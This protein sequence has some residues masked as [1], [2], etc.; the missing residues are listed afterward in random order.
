[1]VTALASLW[2]GVCFA[3]G[4]FGGP[5]V[6]GRSGGAG[7][8]RPSPQVRLRYFA[9]VR[10]VYDSGLT[11]INQDPAAPGSFGLGG[12]EAIFGVVGTKSWRKTQLALT[13]Q[14]GYR[15][16]NQN[17]GFNGSDHALTVGVSHAVGR[18]ATLT[19]S[20]VVATMTRA[21]G[22]GFGLNFLQSNQLDPA[23][24]N[25]P[26]SD[27]LDVRM[28][29]A[30]TSNTLQYRFGPRLSVAATGGLN[31]IQRAGGLFASTGFQARGDISYRISRN[32]TITVDYGAQS[33]DFR[34]SYGNTFLQNVAVQYAAA[35]GRRWQLNLRGG[36][37][38]IK[39]QGLQRVQLRPEIAEILGVRVGLEAFYRVNY[40]P[41][42]QV[43]LNGRFR[44][45]TVSLVANRG[46]IPGNG[47]ILMSS[48]Q[49]VSAS[50]NY[51]GI[52]HWTFSGLG[53]WTRMTNLVRFAAR[54]EGYTAGG[55][56]GYQ[57][58]P[59]LQLNASAIYRDM[60]TTAVSRFQRAGT[61][62]A[63]GLTYSPGDIPLS[64]W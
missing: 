41:N 23:F 42:F 36:G 17:V 54:N 2:A 18:R 26:F 21:F 22:F 49:N 33:F 52:R 4:S 31:T 24:S 59:A 51:V 39:N 47:I 50:Y 32:Q 14:G 3:Q 12:V 25:F 28:N 10:G 62:I 37:F 46:V 44:S 35:I 57:I 56:V 9:T 60:Q 48:T 53:G 6:L 58:R 19:T 8:G 29:F 61:R 16:Y 11:A 30:S 64:L 20:N 1:M 13:Y 43:G 45:S 5:S 63:V 27:M 55:Q 15:Q 40:L 38:E 34:D 7:I